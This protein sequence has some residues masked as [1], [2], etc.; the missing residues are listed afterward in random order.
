MFFD[1]LKK[2]LESRN[3]S[4]KTIK[5]YL[6]YNH[7]FIEHAKKDPKM[8]KESDIKDYIWYLLNDRK[9]SSST[10]RLA[11]IALKYYYCRIKKRKFNY[12]FDLPKK[13]KRLPVILAKE[14]IK[15]IFQ[16][17]TNQKHRLMLALAYGA[18]LRVSE[19]INLKVKD[20]YQIEHLI[21]VSQ[22]KGKKD[23]LTLLPRG[24]LEEIVEFMA[25]KSADDYLFSRSDGKKISSRTAQKIFSQALEAANIRKDATFHSLRHSFATHLLEAG[26]DIRYIQALLGHN[27]LQTT[28][29]YTR[30][31][32]RYLGQIKSPFDS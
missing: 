7:D 3:F 31:S 30:V 27:S 9:I 24:I 5:A 12:L 10:A 19:V 17:I 16:L 13:E 25:G 26:T 21:K 15:K 29:I 6:Y 32:N 8:V 18:G 11:I 22:A 2:D 28:Q 23:R 4:Q 14:E 20:I 1:S